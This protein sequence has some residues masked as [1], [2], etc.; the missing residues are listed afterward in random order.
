MRFH[1]RLIF[2]FPNT[3]RWSSLRGCNSPVHPSRGGV[4]SDQW[5]VRNAIYHHSSPTRD[6]TLT[7]AVHKPQAPTSTFCRELSSSNSW[8]VTPTVSHKCV[9]TMKKKHREEERKNSF[10]VRMTEPWPGLPR[11]A[12]ESPSLEIFQTR[13]DAVLCS[14]LWVTHRGPFQ[15]RPFWDS[16]IKLFQGRFRLDVRIKFLYWKSGWAL[17]Q[18]AQGSGAVP[19]PGGVQNPCGCGTSGHGLAGTVVSG[20]WL[21]LMILEVSSNLDDCLIPRL[22]SM[23]EPRGKRS[24]LEVSP[25]TPVLTFQP[26]DRPPAPEHGGGLGPLAALAAPQGHLRSRRSLAGGG[27]QQGGEEGTRRFWAN[28]AVWQAFARR[29]RPT[30]VQAGGLSVSPTWYRELDIEFAWRKRTTKSISWEDK[31]AAKGEKLQL[32][33]SAMKSKSDGAEI[34]AENT[35]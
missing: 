15:P 4:T 1:G 23:T 35:D 20:W 2:K 32:H 11:E 22:C 18:A 27:Q 26:T 17:D 16:V 9:F 28:S 34:P 25:A 13:L 3:S 6:F 10:P 31:L 30:A 24:C 19:I 5:R 29:P 21:D 12:V 8:G 33:F 7:T 14:L